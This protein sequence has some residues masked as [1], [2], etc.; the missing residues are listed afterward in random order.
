[1]TT[2]R[3]FFFSLQYSDDNSRENDTLVGSSFGKLPDHLLI[4]IFIRIPVLEWAQVS[5]VK[6]QWANLF[7]EECLWQAAL[8]RTYPST[9]HAKRWPGPIPR[10]S[11]RRWSYMSPYWFLFQ[12]LL[13]LPPFL[14]YHSLFYQLSMVFILSN[15]IVTALMAWKFIFLKKQ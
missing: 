11:S 10:G 3:K 7:R 2:R 14:V 13:F 8:N 12:S 9:S 6:K 4:E 1:M 15:A 5:C